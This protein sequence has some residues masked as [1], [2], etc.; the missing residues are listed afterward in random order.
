[1]TSGPISKI[2]INKGKKLRLRR[3]L[4]GMLAPTIGGGF[5]EPKV[6]KVPEAGTSSVGE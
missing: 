2:G 3:I 1:M 4:L 5:L 6:E